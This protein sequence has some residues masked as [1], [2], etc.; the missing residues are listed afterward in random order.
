LHLRPANGVFG[1]KVIMSG[2]FYSL[3]EA[4]E[5]LNKSKAEV[6]QLV[7]EG[8]L[9]EFRDGPNVLF[10]AEEV[11]ALMP[12][13]EVPAPSD[14]EE[15]E[16]PQ[17]EPDFAELG[18]E[19]PQEEDFEIPELAQEPADENPETPEVAEEPAEEEM[20]IPQ[21]E[22][23]SPEEAASGEPVKSEPEIQE[24]PV[25]SDELVDSQ[26]ET[27]IFEVPEGQEVSA[28]EPEKAVEDED[29]DNILLAPETGVPAMDGD[30]TNAD[31]ALTGQGTSILGLT[32]DKDYDLTDD[33]MAE[34]VILDGTKGGSAAEGLDEIEED[35]NLDSFGSGSGLLDLSLQADDTSLGGILDEIYTD[36][37]KE[38][39]VAPEPGSG[40]DIVAES[41][42]I[43]P[44]DVSLTPQIT[45]EA[46]LPLGPALAQ[47]AP[48][49]Q[50][51]ILGML[52]FIPI[53]VVLYTAIIALAGLRGILPSIFTSIQIWIWP[54]M[55]VL[56]VVSIVVAV[57]AVMLTG[58][59]RA[60]VAKARKE[61]APKVKKEKL[62]KP[63][64]QKPQKPKKEKK[65]KKA[66]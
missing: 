23:E 17:D 5:K 29:L 16:A 20:E 3:E 60:P 58:E 30:L 48:D 2:M 25:E 66:K 4:A 41:E 18:V 33:T 27:A 22:Q 7:K 49:S 1:E 19:E 28:E 55:G 36:E 43:A 52:L 37:S 6:R 46:A 54:I 40:T 38:P 14:S 10:K 32:D 15:V 45:P 64:K 21:L 34:T 39:E 42:E 26:M 51:N 61:K 53:A 13:A 57:A 12:E 44:M 8:Q 24:V 62:K 59:R 9:R 47:A 63:K 11:E 35:V 50:S 31:T 65:P 56:G